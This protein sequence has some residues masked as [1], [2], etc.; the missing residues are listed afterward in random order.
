MEP[1]GSITIDT[2]FPLCRNAPAGSVFTIVT[3]TFGQAVTISLALSASSKRLDYNLC[4]CEQAAQRFRLRLARCDWL[5]WWHITFKLFVINEVAHSGKIQSLWCRF[6]V[7]QQTNYKVDY[8]A[9]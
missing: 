6:P 2:R 8:A 7:L 4:G 9:M 5:S 3:V 1:T